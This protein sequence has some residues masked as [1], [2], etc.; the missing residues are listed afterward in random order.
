MKTVEELYNS[1]LSSYYDDVLG[2]DKNDIFHSDGSVNWDYVEVDISDERFME[3]QSTNLF[4][5]LMALEHA[6]CFDDSS[7]FDIS[8]D[9]LAHYGRSL[10]DGA[11]IGSGRYP[12]GSG[13]SAYQHAK[14]LQTTIRSLE[15]AGMNEIQIAKHLQFENTSDLRSRRSSSKEQ[16]KAYEVGMAKKLKASP[17]RE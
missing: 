17:R 6:I 3:L 10:L 4:F 2:S 13:Y 14:N 12:Y 16:I 1:F 9:Y 5:D 7:R 15:K 8:N 11:P